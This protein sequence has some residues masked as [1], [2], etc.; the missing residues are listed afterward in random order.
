MSLLVAEQVAYRY[1]QNN[2]GIAPVSLR[3]GSGEA[4][5]IQG[6]SGCG[7][8]TLA[9]CLTGFVPHLYVGELQGRV[10]VN[11]LP[12]NTTPLWQLSEAVGLL[13]QNPAN[14][15][16]TDSVA[17]EIL[18]GLENM[19][20][21]RDDMRE[22]LEAVLDQFGL[23]AMRQR[24]PL[25]LSGGE[26]QRLALAAVMARQ[27]EVLVLDEPFSML[28]T[29]A[30]A[31]LVA[32]LAQLVDG[33]TAVV[34]CEHRVEALAG[35]SGLRELQLSGGAEPQ[36]EAQFAWPNEG[37][38]PL[39]MTVAGLRVRLGDRP[40]LTN[41]NMTAHSG[42][43][44]AL[45]GRNGVG[46]T[47]LLRALAGLQTFAG[48]AEV[49]GRPPQFG[50]VF[51][52]PDW[53]LFNPSVREEILYRLPEP[54]MSRYR[55]L[56]AALGLGPYEQTPPL[57]LSEGEKK[58]LALATVLMRQPAHGVLLDEPT[59]GQ[60]AAHKAILLRLL[61]QIADSGQLVLITTHDLAVA[62]QCDRLV[63]LGDEGVLADD[64][65]DI[66]FANSAAWAR[67]GLL[68][69]EWLQ[70]HGKRSERHTW[71]A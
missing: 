20:L 57:L 65:P 38:G 1:P 59:L 45:V 68:L 41:F 29:T 24:A 3:V 14:Q 25:T 61:R 42:E 55:Q 70:H 63:L 22:R 60:D 52:N 67:A 21:R 36:G 44:V 58:R 51:Q 18:F 56:L 62:A 34:L 33:G 4:L 17:N 8:S 35:L 49:N 46:K 23:T 66:V 13:F 19:G 10:W 7:K 27:P 40:V 28:D 71:P 32:D 43:V 64:R 30:A 31:D 37:H 53:Q 11:G 39:T 69:P 15:M 6:P 48:S 2:R 9:R 26:Q 54:D 47:T 16:L 50:L 5:L 12:T